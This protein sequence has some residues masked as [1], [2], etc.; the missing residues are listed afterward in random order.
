MITI[1]GMP[2]P[3]MGVVDVVAVRYRLVAAAGTMHMAVAG[4]G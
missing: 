4:V 1:G 2:M 3:V